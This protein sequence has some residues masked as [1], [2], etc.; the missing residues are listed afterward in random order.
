MLL[1][2]PHGLYIIRTRRLTAHELYRKNN[3]QLFTFFYTEILG[4]KLLDPTLLYYIAHAHTNRISRHVDHITVFKSKIFM[5]VN[6][7]KTLCIQRESR[8]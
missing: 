5:V 8:E 2:Q 4:K 7:S 3:C 1:Y 6:E